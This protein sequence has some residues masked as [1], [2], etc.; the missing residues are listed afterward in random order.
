MRASILLGIL[1]A[2]STAARE[3]SAQSGEVHCPPPGTQL[4]FSDGARIEAVAAQANHVCR[5]ESLKTH[6]TFDR[7][8]GAFA[9]TD[10]FIKANA[11]KFQSLIP[12][13]VGRR[14]NFQES[15]AGSYGADGIWFIEVSVERFE[16]VTTAAGTFPAFVILFDERSPQ[17]T[18]GEW[19]YRYWYS[20]DVSHTVKFE[21]LTL[22]GSPP[23]KYPKN[24]ELAAYKPVPSAK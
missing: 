4:T 2:F 8:L 22:R 21:F 20:P 24:W 5:F 15:G 19:Q 1:L 3:S 13:Q 14:I 23:P 17:F 6:G 11:D 16:R 10:P 9:P 18:H 7:L 12:L